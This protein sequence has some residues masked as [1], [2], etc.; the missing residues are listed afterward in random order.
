MIVTS[1]APVRIDFAGGWT[2]V[3]LFAR[4]AGG[5]VLNATINHYVTG[6]M[7]T[8]EDALGGMSVTYGCDLPTGSGLGTSS[9]LNV[10]WLS[11]IKPCVNSR[12]ERRTIA[13]TAFD[14]ETM[15]DILGG[16]QDQYAAAFGGFNFLTFGETV[17]VE[18]LTLPLETV[19]A[20]E[21]R[22]VLCYTGRPRL[23]GSIHENVWSAF[24]RGVPETVEALYALRD[25]AVRMKVALIAGEPGRVRGA[26]VPEL[27]AAEGARPVR[28]QSR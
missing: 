9:A 17:C 22:L 28:D 11:L 27:D 2:D 6:R 24:R 16:K 21:S 26:A 18:T 8:S 10:V 15:L 20:L 5:A 25:I 3:D 14:L 23:S 19:C 13:E 7:E 4:G 12:E 1:R